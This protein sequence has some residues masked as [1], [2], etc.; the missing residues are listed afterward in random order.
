MSEFYATATVYKDGWI[1]SRPWHADLTF[2]NG[3]VWK[4]WMSSFRSKKAVLQ[5]IEACGPKVKVEF[6]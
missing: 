3:T 6:K 2:D 1:V 5:A 4:S